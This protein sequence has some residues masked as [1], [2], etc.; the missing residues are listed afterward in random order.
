[1]QMDQVAAG[2]F[3]RIRRKVRR[4]VIDGV[5]D[6]ERVSVDRQRFANFIYA[7]ME[8]FA[9]ENITCMVVVL[10]EIRGRGA[11]VKNAK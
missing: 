6:L 9:V 2:L 4:V 10:L 8:W 1:M 11:V 3:Q 7:L 5:D